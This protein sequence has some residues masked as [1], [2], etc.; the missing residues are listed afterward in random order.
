M[1]QTPVCRYATRSGALASAAVSLLRLSA[2]ILLWTGPAWAQDNPFEQAAQQSYAGRFQGEGVE[3]RLIPEAGRWKGT[4]LLKGKSLA[5]EAEAKGTALE[6]RY[7]DGEQSWPFTGIVNGD[8]FTF[9]SGTFTATLTRQRLPKLE[10]RWRS[11]RVLIIFDHTPGKFGGRIQYGG[12]DYTFAAEE[13]A[14]DLEGVFKLGD[15]SF[16]FRL[17]NETRGVVFNSGSFA[18]VI[19]PVPNQG[20]LRVQTT[21]AVSFTLRNGGEAVAGHDG[22]YIFPGGQALTLELSAKGYQPARTNLSLPDYGESTWTVK[23][24]VL[25]YPRLE[26]PWTNSL[27]MKLA[28]VAGTK[29]LFGVWDVRVKDYAAYAAASSGVDGSWKE[30]GFAQAETHPVVKVSWD[31][32][33]AFCQWLTKAERAKNLIGGEQEYRLP[34]DAEWSVAVGLNESSSDTP[35]SKSMKVPGVYP[36]GTQWPPPTG[37]GNYAKLSEG[38]GKKATVLYD[39]GYEYTSPVGSFKA[40]QFGLYDMGGNVW[41]WCEDWYDDEL[42]YLVLR[43]ASWGLNHPVRLLSSC[44]YCVTPDGRINRIGFR[45]VLGGVASR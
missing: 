31:D 23:L 32:A 19:T 44:R 24:E 29:V 10:G 16:P 14:G 35:A 7:V 38:K 9:T 36:W 34:T 12:A 28:P 3:L 17:A 30:P 26:Q 2:V 13:K 1:R 21:P 18:E 45:C 37:A 39:D 43:G 22:V 25:P 41:Q 15:K 8:R 42:I 27:G 40:N 5:V 11:E 4:V 20:T 33:K 6:G